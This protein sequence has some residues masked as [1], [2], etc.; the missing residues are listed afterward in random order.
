MS[1]VTFELYAKRR[2]IV[3]SELVAE[4]EEGGRVLLLTSGSTNSGTEL[5]EEKEPLEI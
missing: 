4:L 5:K 1:L 3:V 2:K